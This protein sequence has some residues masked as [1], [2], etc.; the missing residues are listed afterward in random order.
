M[1]Y[2]VIVVGGGVAG[3]T[4]AWILGRKGFSVALIESKPRERIGTKPCGDAIGLHHFRELG[5]EPPASVI[6]NKFYGVRVYSPSEEHYITV[7][8]EGIGINSLRFHQWLLR[9]ALDS[10]V[11]LLDRHVLWSI[12]VKEGFVDKVVVKKKGVAGHIELRAKAY[13]DASGAT[14][15]LRLKLPREWPIAEKPYTT[16]YNITYREIIELN[17]PVDSENRR[18]AH[19]YLNK[20]IAPGGYWWFF[21]KKDGSI[22]NMG[23]GVIWRS[24]SPNP[25]SQYDRFLRTRFK[26]RAIDIGGGL[27]PTRRPLPTLVW[28]NVCVVGDAAYTVNPVHGGGKGSSMLAASII[29]RHLGDALEAG[30]VDEETLWGV[31]IDYL[32]AYGSKQAMLD[33]LRMY[34]QMLSNSDL[35]FLFKKKIVSGDAVYDI[36]MKGSLREELVRN[37][38]AALSLIGRPSLLNQL[39]MVKR[40]MDTANKLYL[41]EYP[42]EPGGL[43]EWIG[44]VEELYNRFTATIGF[45]KGS[46][47]RW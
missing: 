22:A 44:R 47:V 24:G 46:V 18:Y 12:S 32:K 39:R 3:L 6:E 7:Y 21:P 10:G 34:L 9:E 1:V 40:Y 23:L 38:K 45:E 30:R 26:G 35:E 16:D 8:G 29:A 17:E 43:K 5:F 42:R 41:E 2:D 25:R 20:D 4:S 13:I 19:I 36:G 33:I 11:E 37:I 28:R 15:A 14:P 31:N 27:V